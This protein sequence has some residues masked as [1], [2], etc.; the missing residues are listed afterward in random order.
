MGIPTGPRKK[1]LNELE[2]VKNETSRTEDKNDTAPKGLSSSSKNQGWAKGVTIGSR[3]PGS[4]GGRDRSYTNQIRERWELDFTELSFVGVIGKG[5]FGIVSKARWRSC[6]VV[7]KKLS[8]Q[9]LNEEQIEEFRSE[10]TILMNLRPHGNL[11]QFLG[12][13]FTIPNL[14]LVTEYLPLGDLRKLIKKEKL[15]ERTKIGISLGA[16]AGMRH[17]HQEGILHR[18]LAARNLLVT[19]TSSGEYTVKVADLVYQNKEILIKV[20]LGLVL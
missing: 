3:I 19:K 4:T 9:S 17:L 15:E 10:L 8:N 18:D 6:E 7:V 13:C 5:A 11:V 14:C 16:A 1:I 2:R 20:H 12:A